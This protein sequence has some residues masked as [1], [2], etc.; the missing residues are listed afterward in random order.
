MSSRLEQREALDS[1][2]GGTPM[3]CFFGPSLRFVGQH[4][5][6]SVLQLIVSVYLISKLSRCC[7]RREDNTLYSY[8]VLILALD[9][10]E[11]RI[12]A[13]PAAAA[14]ACCSCARVSPPVRC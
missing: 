1:S 5:R 12:V 9:G 14:V 7:T 3:L 2:T 10:V 11:N 4:I 8:P 6:S 13:A